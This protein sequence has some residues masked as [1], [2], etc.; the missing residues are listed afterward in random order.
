MCGCA[1]HYRG[2]SVDVRECEWVLQCGGNQ[3]YGLF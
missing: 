3:I 2:G 1:I